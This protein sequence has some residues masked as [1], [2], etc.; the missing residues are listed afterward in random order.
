MKNEF[1]GFYSTPDKSL[2]S[3]W[4]DG[5]TLFV[6][7][8]N[9]L[10]NL[11]RCE[12]GTR[13]D[14]IK[15][16]K[17]LSPRIWIPFQ[18]GYE[19]QRTRRTVIEESISSL[20]NI[21]LEL[22]KFYKQSILEQAGIKKHLYNKLNSDISEFQKSLQHNI[23]TF[24][25]S[26]IDVRIESKEK[27]SKHDFIRDQLDAIISGN[28]GSTPTQEE[29]D[30]IN[31]LGED[32]YEKKI[33]PGY[34]DSSKKGVS[35]YSDI[36]FK[37][38]FGD[39]YIW[40]QLIE[41][42]KEDK[43]ETVVFVSDDLKADWVFVHKGITHG[44]L[45]SLKTEIC[46]RSNIKNFRLINQLSFLRE[47]KEYLRNVN[48]SVETLN[49]VKELVMT[50]VHIHTKANDSLVENHFEHEFPNSYQRGVNEGF[51]N[52][53]NNARSKVFKE[54]Q[55]LVLR[56]ETALDDFK[57][58]SNDCKE[59]LALM[60][61]YFN[62]LSEMHSKFSI[63]NFIRELALVIKRAEI[64]THNITKHNIS[65]IRPDKINLKNLENLTDALEEQTNEL[66]ILNELAESYIDTLL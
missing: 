41:K 4:K 56:S 38:K 23:D 2:E 18:V 22:I 28:V 51:V 55:D 34:K 43:I 42:A 61:K 11:Y 13:E 52:Y 47:A 17:E 20:S 53:F 30:R 58:V 54:A 60:K 12:D 64:S 16:M 39:L 35:Y 32:R 62:E 50:P 25:S 6:L 44:P 65:S 31:E 33:P 5:T 29:I 3:V 24:I 45:E 14:I 59:K 8:T 36:I 57:E 19:Y 46:K 26:K 21:K 48:V 7:D 1:C 37:D 9:C 66:K 63:E 40:E 27:I 10:L 15:V 49:E